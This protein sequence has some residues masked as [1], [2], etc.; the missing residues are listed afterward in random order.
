LHS[1]SSSERI[2]WGAIGPLI[3]T[4]AIAV[5][6]L[7]DARNLFQRC[8]LGGGILNRFFLIWGH[9]RLNNRFGLV[10]GFGEAGYGFRALGRRCWG[11]D[12]W[13]LSLNGCGVWTEFLFRL[14]LRRLLWFWR[15]IEDD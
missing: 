15:L 6:A 8:G 2:G 4:K 7:K 10:W 5:C 11:R 9:R 14:R 13:L 12:V 1:F 3:A